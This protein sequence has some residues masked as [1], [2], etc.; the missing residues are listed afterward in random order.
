MANYLSNTISVIDGFN[1]REISNISVGKLP[2]SIVIASSFGPK[3]IPEKI[4]VT[5]S[6]SNTVSVIN[7]SNDKEISRVPV[8]GRNMVYTL[9]HSVALRQFY[10]PEKIYVNNS[11]S[12]TVSVI[13]ASNDK[14]ISRIPVGG[15]RCSP[16]PPI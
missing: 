5:N 11:L 16:L 2:I 14:E 15:T 9:R 3:V 10:Y 12:N 13:N 8:G 1:D 4:Y 6:G 7:A